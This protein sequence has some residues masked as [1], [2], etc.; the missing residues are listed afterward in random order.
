MN[1]F[2]GDLDLLHVM[3]LHNGDEA[4]GL[5]WDEANT[6]KGKLRAACVML[7][8]SLVTKGGEALI[9]WTPIK[10]RLFQGDKPVHEER[11]RLSGVWWRHILAVAHIPDGHGNLHLGNDYEEWVQ[12]IPKFD[13]DED[14]REPRITYEPPALAPP[15]PHHPPPVSYNENWASGDWNPRSKKKNKNYVDAE[16]QTDEQSRRAMIREVTGRTAKD[17]RQSI[18]GVSRP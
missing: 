13:I 3:N 1:M 10:V 6:A 2:Q 4:P 11:V 12:S 14:A 9:P 17:M 8:A 7:E 16:M 5:G 18:R 15:A